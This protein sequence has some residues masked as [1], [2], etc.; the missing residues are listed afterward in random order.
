MKIKILVFLLTIS[1]GFISY[2]YF[3]SPPV[4]FRYVERPAEEKYRAFVIFNPFRNRTPELPAE[5]VL[6]QMKAGDFEKAFTLTTLSQ[7]RIDYYLQHEKQ[8]TFVD[9]KLMDRKD[10]E[11]KIK[12]YYLVHRKYKEEINGEHKDKIYEQHVIITVEKYSNIW[13]VIDYSAIY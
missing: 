11:N 1:L 5:A 2:V 9:W 8:G 7:E 4:F 13:R 6:K 3:V 12:L 10:G